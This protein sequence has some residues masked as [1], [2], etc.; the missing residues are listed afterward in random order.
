[1]KKL[2]K[3]VSFFAVLN[4]AAVLGLIGWLIASGR[5]DKERATEIR[6]MLSETVE[7]R[8]AREAAQNEQAQGEGESLPDPLTIE[9]R[10]EAARE[11]GDVELMRRLRD[12]QNN[13]R[14]LESLHREQRELDEARDKFL[15]ERDAF[16]A[17]RARLAEI[18][19]D[20]QF[21]KSLGVYEGMKAPDAAKN[22]LALL[23]QG[24]RDEVVSYLDAM[25]ERKRIKIFTELTKNAQNGLA[26]QLLEDLRTRGLVAR[27]PEVSSP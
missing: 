12:Q 5:L 24:K 16:N 2:L 13:L 21:R 22:L 6:A 3:L 8:A 17:M 10:I 20:E 23:D 19:G 18:E 9:Q 11:A 1:M 26:A 25:D 14:M 4:F 15:A 7:Q 27:A